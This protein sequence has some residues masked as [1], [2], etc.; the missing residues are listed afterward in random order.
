DQ[1]GGFKGRRTVSRPRP[2][3]GLNSV[4]SPASAGLIPAEMI[5]TLNK[6]PR[7]IPSILQEPAS[8][9]QTRPVETTP[10][11]VQGGRPSTDRVRRFQILLI[12]PLPGRTVDGAR[13]Y[14]HVR[15]RD[16]AT[17]RAQPHPIR[18]MRTSL[19]PRRTSFLPDSP[20]ACDCIV[21]Q[22]QL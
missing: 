18:R 21:P 17:S 14:M 19:N 1:K 5:R 13:P 16:S 9:Q 22:T 12:L 20:H 8:E 2:T 10:V 7:R 15:L 4:R 11:V 6:T 3:D